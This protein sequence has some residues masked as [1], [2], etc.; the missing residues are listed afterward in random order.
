VAIYLLPFIASALLALLYEAKLVRPG[1]LYYGLALL[2]LS[3]FAGLRFEVG[4]DWDAY[5]AFFEGLEVKANI[6]EIYSKGYQQFDIGYYLL[7][8]VV[9]ALDG[10][11]HLVF[12]VVALFLT[13]SIYM[14]TRHYLI[15]RF[16]ILAI[17]IS[18]T[19]IILN[20]A[21]VR[22]AAAVGFF[23]LGCDQYLR[24]HNK[25][26]ALLVAT[27]GVTLQYSSLMY[28]VLLAVV[29]YWPQKVKKFWIVAIV[30][31][32]VAGLY[33]L[34]LFMDFY[35]ILTYLAGT[36]SAQDKVEIYRDLQTSQGPWLQI[37]GVFLLLLTY[38]FVRYMPHVKAEQ[39]FIVRFAI[40]S[41][42]M[43]I[44]FILIFPGS[45]VMYS[46]AYVVAGFFQAYAAAIIFSSSKRKWQHTTIFTFTLLASW[47][48]Y[49]R[50]IELY[51]DEYLPYKWTLSLL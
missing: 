12:L 39:V 8:Y 32:S 46:R 30:V 6:L 25:L 5:E 43:A 37:Y 15:N 48:Y 10:S 18:N 2:G 1:R 35:T 27:I 44:V 26:R 47:I 33:V 42:S 19:F 21:Q 50:I 14:F 51:K 4:Q 41:I 3:L 29:L 45:Y 31:I 40:V 34:S 20:F 7:N 9:K 11:Y 16:Y 28:I 49:Y 24:S 17:Y 13:Y 38:Y 36:A 23:I 22:Q